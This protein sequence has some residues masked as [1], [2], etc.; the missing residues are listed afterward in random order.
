MGGTI[1]AAVGTYAA[2]QIA[3][4]LGGAAASTSLLDDI[5]GGLPGAAISIFE[6][7]TGL[8]PSKAFGGNSQNAEIGSAIGG[9]LGTAL[10]I[11]V[12]GTVIGQFVGS[13]IGSVFGPPASVGP[14]SSTPITVTNGLY[15]LG[16]QSSDNNASAS[17]ISTE[18]GFAQATVTLLN[19]ELTAVG[20]TVGG[21]TGLE[22]TRIFKQQ[23]WDSTN[24][25]P[26]N[27]DF[28]NDTA[29]SFSDY[30]SALNDA[31]IRQLQ[32]TVISG[33]DPVLA[34]AMRNS[35]AS[36][37]VNYL[38]DAQ[39]G[40]TSIINPSNPNLVLPTTETLQ[41]LNYDLQAVED[42]NNF[43]QNKVAFLVGFAARYSANA[44]EQAA[45][46]TA[47]GN[48]AAAAADVANAPAAAL[49]A[50]NQEFFR[51]ALLQR[52]WSF[53]SSSTS[54]SVLDFSSTNTGH[55]G[56]LI[57]DSSY[58]LANASISRSGDN[59]VITLSSTKAVTV[60]DAFT[61][62]QYTLGEV[63]FTNLNGSA[64]S[65]WNGADLQ[66]L[67]LA[68]NASI[69][70]SAITVVSGSS[71][72]KTIS[73]NGTYTIVNGNTD[74][75]TLNGNS[76][77]IAL[78]GTGNKLTLSGS[79]NRISASGDQNVLSISGN[80]N[81]AVA[82]GQGDT[83]T[84]NGTS[85]TLTAGG[86]SIT[87]VN[88]T[89]GTI[90]GIS[91]T[92]ALVDSDNLTVGG[93]SMTVTIS[94]GSDTFKI[95][96]NSET[97]TVTSAG[98]QDHIEADG[99]HDTLSVIG[100]SNTITINGTSDALTVSGYGNTIA[101]NGASENTITLS[102]YGNLVAT[103]G[104]TITFEDSSGGTITGGGNIVSIGS[105]DNVELSGAGFESTLL[106]NYSTVDYDG[107]YGSATISGAS[108][109]LTVEGD[110]NV[111]TVGG[112]G[113][114]VTVAGLGERL[115]VSGTGQSIAVNGGTV[116]V[117]AGAQVTFV[118]GASGTYTNGS[119][120]DVGSGAT[121]VVNGEG[122]S[123][124]WVEASSSDT[125]TL[126]G[127]GDGV[128]G[129]GIGNKVTFNGA[130]QYGYISSATLNL[131]SGSQ[132]NRKRSFSAWGVTY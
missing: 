27:A 72:T 93:D 110:K 21:T 104:T 33:G 102:N 40:N 117:A 52:V 60:T 62:N 68:G 25:V 8:D 74:T 54:E 80:S 67:L 18:A 98:S 22:F 94:G 29:R 69:K 119:I 103:A 75:I 91:D 124:D 79:S 131:T 35:F 34:Q 1:G 23:F 100:A 66:T 37:D 97:L 57:L 121:V 51:G 56:L 65:T 53:L 88:A 78:N 127:T 128:G 6:Q 113:N 19:A 2:A 10:P 61:S 55:E 106:G 9:L 86:D 5:E 105:S 90:N 14:N 89:T 45:A 50:W 82:N 17:L 101:V 109:T 38:T 116:N 39:Y 92:I 59:L 84:L 126:N 70:F 32:M 7:L 114:T 99:Q 44:D 46:D 111:V 129:S 71:L 112:A 122:N 87:L 125:I 77:G 48:T 47:A 63:E 16:P 95:G 43:F 24:N 36:Y 85:E 130:N 30:S 12:V 42:Y 3:N 49:A 73:G 15:A 20:G 107:G 108:N 120:I 123:N 58:A 132:V 28:P 76:G 64:A 81:T 83:I 4:E 96:G 13:I 115:S 26:A 118:S 41:Q 31:V 11:P